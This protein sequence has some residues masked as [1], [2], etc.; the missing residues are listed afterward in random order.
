MG[1]YDRKDDV[2]IEMLINEVKTL[3]IELSEHMHEEDKAI[4]DLVEAFNTARHV[5]WFVKVTAAVV[6]GVA[7]TWAFLHEHFHIGIK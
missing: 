3:R 5:V 7:L 6:A 1:E 2:L 4:K